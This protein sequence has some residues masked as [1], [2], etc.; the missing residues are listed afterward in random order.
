MRQHSGLARRNPTS[1]KP[2]TG[3]T[4]EDKDGKEV[5]IEWHQMT[6]E[7]LYEKLKTGPKGLSKEQVNDWIPQHSQQLPLP[8]W[9]VRR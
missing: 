7:E 3:P 9:L 8:R 6:D 5:E 1:L 4:E 2:T